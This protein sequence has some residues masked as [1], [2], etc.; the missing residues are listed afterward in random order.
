MVDGLYPVACRYETVQPGMVDQCQ[1][2]GDGMVRLGSEV[3]DEGRLLPGHFDRR[4]D[5][6]L[7]LVLVEVGLGSRQQEVVHATCGRTVDLVHR[8]VLYTYNNT[9]SHTDSV[10]I[11][12][13]SQTGKKGEKKTKMDKY[14]DRSIISSAD[15]QADKK[16][17]RP[18]G[19]MTEKSSRDKTALKCRVILSAPTT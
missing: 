17:A 14:R 6:P 18:G 9:F 5:D 15:R 13:N 7:G 11:I 12:P 3:T 4:A 19:R 8:S 2:D 1:R 10:A 16:A